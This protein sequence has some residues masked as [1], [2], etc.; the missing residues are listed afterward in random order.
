MS[1]ERWNVEEIERNAGMDD[2]QRR[3]MMHMQRIRPFVRRQDYYSILGVPKTA[4][5]QEI[6]T[7]YRKIALAVAPDKNPG[8]DTTEI[9]QTVNK[10]YEVL[11]DESKR[12]EYDAGG[13][14]DDLGD[15]DEEDVDDSL[16]QFGSR[17]TTG[18][19]AST[20]FRNLYE[21][22]KANNKP[23]VRG[24]YPVNERI[25]RCT[26][27]L[28]TR[29]N[30]I[31]STGSQ[32][33]LPS[34]IHCCVCNVQLCRPADP[35]AKAIEEEHMANEH[36]AYITRIAMVRTSLNNPSSV[37]AV[38]YPDLVPCPMPLRR[39]LLPDHTNCPPI[40]FRKL[41][42]EFCQT[43]RTLFEECGEW[44]QFLA[45]LKASEDPQSGAMQLSEIKQNILNAAANL[46]KG[47]CGRP[48]TKEVSS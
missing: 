4:T 10:A 5:L 2:R 6:K 21:T 14:R 45:H 23:W 47:P 16:A 25:K 26:Q 3:T 12:R 31:A 44:R 36:N 8:L 39:H 41:A 29:I 46:P 32:K 34:F 18:G 37:E 17:L 43:P 22:E 9:F 40:L 42:E 38:L 35:R 48:P 30:A 33:P 11:S 13:Q 28:C 20:M 19:R 7:S 27:D 24:A 15:D 1:G